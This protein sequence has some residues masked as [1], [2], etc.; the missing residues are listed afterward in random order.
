MTGL[1]WTT[2]CAASSRKNGGQ[3]FLVPPYAASPLD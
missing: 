3:H 2:Q 1:F